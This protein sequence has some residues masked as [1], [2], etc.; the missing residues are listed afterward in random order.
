VRRSESTR[1]ALNGELIP[2]DLDATLAIA[3]SDKQQAAPTWKRTFGLHPMT[4]WPATATPAPVSRWRRCGG[5]TPGP[6]RRDHLEAT[7]V[8]LIR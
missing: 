8:A 2:I 5:V 1:P 7:R 4:P 6:T 3:H